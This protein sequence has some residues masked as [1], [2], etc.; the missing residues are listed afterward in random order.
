MEDI[1]KILDDSVVKYKEVHS[2]RWLS[3]FKAVETVYRTLDSLITYFDSLSD[4]PKAKGMKK[5]I[6]QELFIS[7]TYGMMDW[8]KPIMSLSQFFQQKNIDVG[9]VKVN[10]IK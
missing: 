1:Q 7:I 9:V 10:V 3:F 6:A 8:L 5:K 4:D 2:V